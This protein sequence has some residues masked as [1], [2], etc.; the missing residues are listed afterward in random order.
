M[1]DSFVYF[2]LRSCVRVSL[3]DISRSEIAGCKNINI[4]TF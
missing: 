4:F 2:H 1:V 3:E